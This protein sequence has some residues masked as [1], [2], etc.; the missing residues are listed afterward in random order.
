M[1]APPAV[2]KRAVGQMCSHPGCE[3]PCKTKGF[4]SMHYHRLKRGQPLDRV[5]QVFCSHP[6]CEGPYYAKAVCRFHYNQR[7]EVKE[8]RKARR[9]KP[10]Q[11]KPCTTCGNML[12]VNSL[13]RNCYC[14]KKCKSQAK[15]IKAKEEIRRKDHDPAY[16]RCVVPDCDRAGSL[17]EMCHAHYVRER[18]KKSLCPPIRQ[19]KQGNGEWITGQ[20]YVI[21]ATSGGPM[22]K[23]RFVIE[24][25]IGRSL[26]KYETVHHI[27][28]DRADNRIE[29]LELFSSSHPPGQRIRDK[30]KHAKEIIA[31]YDNPL[32]RDL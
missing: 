15:N 31:L 17:K 25:H 21:K 29:N 1:D 27:N 20:G 5:R 23:H 18:D 13:G 30:L 22:R 11:R 16:P 26:R 14:S 32:F 4:C 10:E 9:R 6:G 24:Q 8:R 2:V 28:G 3:C 7:T 19:Y 12:T